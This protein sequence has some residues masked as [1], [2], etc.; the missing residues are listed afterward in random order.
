MF[1]QELAQNILEYTIIFIIFYF[2]LTINSCYGIEFHFGAVF[3]FRR[4]L[5]Q[6]L[7]R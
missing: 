2:N 1:F 7:W 3:F 5:N 6:F 4:H